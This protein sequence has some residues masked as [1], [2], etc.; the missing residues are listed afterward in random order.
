MDWLAGDDYGD[1]QDARRHS[2]GIEEE[3]HARTFSTLKKTQ[4][5]FFP[6]CLRNQEE[7]KQECLHLFV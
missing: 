3:T 5:P 7:S 2:L 4:I 1:Q 6:F